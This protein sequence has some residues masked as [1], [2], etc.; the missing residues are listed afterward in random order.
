MRGKVSLPFVVILLFSLV[1][2][3]AD[4]QTCAG[5]Y[6][7]ANGVLQAYHAYDANAVSGTQ[8]TRLRKTMI[9]RAN[10]FVS[11]ASAFFRGADGIDTD[12]D[13]LISQCD[14]DTRID[15]YKAA[16]ETAVFFARTGAIND[17][18]WLDAGSLM[19]H[20]L[21]LVLQKSNRQDPDLPQL[22]DQLKRAYTRQHLAINQDLLEVD[23]DVMGHAAP[24]GHHAC[25]NPDVEA[26]VTDPVQPDYPESARD[27]GLGAVTLE[28]EVTVGANGNFIGAQV[29]K[30][31][32]N[33]AIDQAA[34]LAARESSYSPRM[35]DCQPT[36]GGSLFR[37]FLQPH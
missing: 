2:A 16:V 36:Q 13:A 3:K 37:A 32:G 18:S 26:T 29:Y 14:N 19:I 6:A 20:R 12:A 11:Y 5:L 15:V 17:K 9:V 8:A 4:A 7:T 27:L 28:V 10:E 33:M 21:T 35:V 31:S 30:S 23:A 24:K 22:D 1:Y 25:A 34:L